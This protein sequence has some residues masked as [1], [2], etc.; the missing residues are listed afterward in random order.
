MPQADRDKYVVNN[1]D[2]LPPVVAEAILTAPPELSGVAE[3]HR[4]LLTEKVLEAQHPGEMTQVSDLQRAIEV[5]ERAVEIG[6]D[7]V[8]IEAGVMDTHE[9]DA[10]AA[11]IERQHKAPWLRKRGDEIRVVDLERKV[12]RIASPE[13]IEAGVYYENAQAYDRGQAA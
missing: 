2:N 8:R 3:T 4:A 12:E 9:F 7:E 13:E 1:L 6:R 11:P 5:A 10:M